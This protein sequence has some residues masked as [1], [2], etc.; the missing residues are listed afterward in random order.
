MKS[1]CRGIILSMKVKRSLEH[2]S[3]FSGTRNTDIS[4]T[5]LPS[6]TFN[7]LGASLASHSTL[8]MSL[9]KWSFMR[10]LAPNWSTKTFLGITRFTMVDAGRSYIILFRSE[11][12]TSELQSP[13]HLV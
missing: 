12:H 4:C 1:L 11:E 8:T 7:V 9:V 2:S 10:V 13:D 3:S 5:T 6:A